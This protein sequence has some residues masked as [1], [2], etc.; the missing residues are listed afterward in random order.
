MDKNNQSTSSR[1]F[2]ND[3]FLSDSRRRI[4]WS[5]ERKPTSFVVPPKIPPLIAKDIVSIINNQIRK[6]QTPQVGNSASQVKPVHYWPQEQ[7]PL[8]S[9]VPSKDL[10]IDEMMNKSNPGTRT[11][12]VSYASKTSKRGRLFDTP[13]TNPTENAVTVTP[14]IGN[15][16][17]SGKPLRESKSFVL[18][19]S[20]ASKTKEFS[21][22]SSTLNA[23]V[24]KEFQAKPQ[25]PLAKTI[26]NFTFSDHFDLKKTQIMKERPRKDVHLTFMREIRDQTPEIPQTNFKVMFPSKMNS[27][28]LS[29]IPR[30]PLALKRASSSVE[31]ARLAL[32]LN[33]QKSA[34]IEDLQEL[35]RQISLLKSKIASQEVVCSSATLQS[36]LQKQHD[37][38]KDYV[39]LEHA[40]TTLK[41]EN[42]A[43]RK[44]LEA[45]H[46]NAPK[47]LDSSGSG[48]HEFL[49]RENTLLRS[50]LHQTARELEAMNQNK[51]ETIKAQVLVQLQNEARFTNLKYTTNKQA[52]VC[53]IK[54][55]LAFLED[56]MTNRPSI[57][58]RPSR[59]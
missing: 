35:D 37:I 16:Q 30:Q 52:I 9:Q 23:A 3:P 28:S 19:E 39:L 20:S 27:L 25:T 29:S 14:S 57:P 45:Y 5:T 26:S 22:I 41:A 12:D 1:S 54:A 55:Y 50:K 48:K 15:S 47:V 21:V 59:F 18:T 17:I 4:E 40:F 34:L 8:Q 2:I 31:S 49:L 10:Y 7:L 51:I 44:R 6:P 56:K 33:S 53:D 42:E 24:L 58:N 13:P 46:Y 36:T 11:F 38:E 43:N 32:D